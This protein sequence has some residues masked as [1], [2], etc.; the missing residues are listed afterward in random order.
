MKKKCEAGAKEIEVARLRQITERAR[1]WM[2]VKI[3]GDAG[4]SGPAPSRAPLGEFPAHAVVR[5]HRVESAVCEVCAGRKVATLAKR[6]MGFKSAMHTVVLADRQACRY[7]GSKR[8][9][10]LLDQARWR[11]TSENM[12]TGPSACWLR[13]PGPQSAASSRERGGQLQRGNLCITPQTCICSPPPPP[14]PRG[15]GAASG[16]DAR[17]HCPSSTSKHELR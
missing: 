12:D 1:L 5:G 17:S 4:R 6:W 16:L 15:G 14:P 8:L 7:T 3:R 11:P 13:L 9:S 10:R 2:A